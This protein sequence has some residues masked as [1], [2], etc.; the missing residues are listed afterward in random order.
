MQRGKILYFYSLDTPLF[1]QVSFV[2]HS[3]NVDNV[4][5]QNFQFSNISDI[6]CDK[7]CAYTLNQMIYII[8]CSFWNISDMPNDK[9]CTY[10]LN[11]IIYNI[12]HAFVVK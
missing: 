1:C 10:T 4:A 2:I 7:M 12:S 8:L 5:L 3:N 9:S 6:L 11:K